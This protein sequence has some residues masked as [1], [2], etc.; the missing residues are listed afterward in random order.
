MNCFATIAVT[1]V[2]GVMGVVACSCTL[3]SSIGLGLGLGKAFVNQGS[4]IVRLG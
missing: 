1:G 2:A 4:A 3:G